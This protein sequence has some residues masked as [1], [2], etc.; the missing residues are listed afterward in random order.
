MCV[1]LC[2]GLQNCPTIQTKP[3]QN[4]KVSTVGIAKLLRELELFKAPGPDGIQNTVLKSC[5]DNIA[6]IL[7]MIFQR[8]LDTGR[9]PADW[10]EVDILAAFKRGDRHDAENY[11]PIS[12]TPVPSKILEHT[13][14]RHIFS[15]RKTHT[16][17]TNLNHS[18]RSGYSCETQLVTTVNDFLTSFGNNRQVDVAVLDFSKAFYMVP[19]RKSPTQTPAVW[20]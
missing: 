4:L 11:R 17:L 3:I 1:F 8:S 14:C 9:L 10:L 18:F 2:F 16:I 12:L 15:H 20:H 7:C 5:A 19:H 13:I 6:P